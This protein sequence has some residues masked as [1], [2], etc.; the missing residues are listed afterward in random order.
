MTGWPAR[1]AG[2]HSSRDRMSLRTL[3]LVALALVLAPSLAG[4]QSPVGAPSR[5]SVG[6]A[7]M[8][9]QPLG[10]FADNVKQGF[11]LDGFGA[12][13]LDS[14]GI[15]S[16]R[17]E[18]GYLQYATKSEYFLVNTGFGLLELKSET[19]SGV[20]ML[21][22]GPHIMAPTGAI[23]PYIGGTVGFARF[24]TNTA[25]KI[26]ADDSNTGEE[27]TLDEQTISSDFIL[28]IG[29]SAGLAISIPALAR[30]GVLI[31]LGARYHRNGLAKYV[32]SEG[33]EYN[34]TGTPTVTATES[35][36]DFI[37]YRIG[38]VIPIR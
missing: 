8:Y 23:R 31:D 14:R 20:L 9:G 19:K 37:V 6:A 35:E 28:S 34:G 12:L 22:A 4:A 38:V 21:G 5:F 32:S 15:F 27:E 29:A 17:A 18:L 7:G 30:S 26:D 33:V 25:I 10:E 13:A 1:T 3:R 11:G 16:L 24:A 36:A 2:R